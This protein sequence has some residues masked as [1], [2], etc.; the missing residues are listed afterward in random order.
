MKIFQIQLLYSILLLKSVIYPHLVKMCFHIFFSGSYIYFYIG[1]TSKDNCHITFYIDWTLN[2]DGTL[3]Y[4]SS[5]GNLLKKCYGKKGKRF[6]E[7]MLLFEIYY[8]VQI[9]YVSMLNN[10]S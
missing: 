9:I 10:C 7:I 2:T 4:K 5:F 6:V 1:G 8:I 3:L